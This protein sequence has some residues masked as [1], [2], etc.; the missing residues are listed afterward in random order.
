MAIDKRKKIR[1]FSIDGEDVALAGH[2]DIVIQNASGYSILTGDVPNTTIVCVDADGQLVGQYTTAAGTG[3]AVSFAPTKTGV[4][5][6]VATRDG[7]IAWSK[8]IVVDNIGVFIAGAGPINDYT[9]EQLGLACKYGYFNAM[10]KPTEEWTYNDEDSILNDL[11]FVIEQL[12]LDNGISVADFRLK[13]PYSKVT[14]KWNEYFAYLSSATAT[15]FSAQY[16]SAGGYKY[17]TVRQTMM[18]KGDEVYMQATGIKP[19]GSTVSGG[20]EFSKLFYTKRNGEKSGIY[21]YNPDEDAFTQ[22]TAYEQLTSSTSQTNVKFMKGYFAVATDIDIE[23]FSA[24]YYYTRATVSKAYVYTHATEYVEG[25]TY[26]G[27]YETLQDDGV[28]LKALAKVRDYLVPFEDYSST[29]LTNTTYVSKTEDLVNILCIEEFTGLNRTRQTAAGKQATAMYFYNIA[30]EGNKIDIY[31]HERTFLGVDEWTRSTGS[32]NSITACYLH[33]YGSVNSNGVYYA[34]ALR[35][36][37]R[38]TQ[39]QT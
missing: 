31:N 12:K 14:Y 21:S 15:S 26:Y 38:F 5:S 37:F 24:S 33:Y 17:S 28:F 10:F 30:G 11:V 6:L 4:Y 3:G 7:K 34:Y 39:K 18:K 35:V 29:G 8:Q 27:F 22:D 13:A 32:Y 25:T 1:R 19:D 2:Q 16:S 36:G 23:N 9:I 20:I